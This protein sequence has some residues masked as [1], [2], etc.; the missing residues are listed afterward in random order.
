MHKWVLD[1]LHCDWTCYSIDFSKL[2]IHYFSQLT[3]ATVL[4]TFRWFFEDGNGQCSKGNSSA[5]NNWRVIKRCYCYVFSP[6]R[7]I[8]KKPLVD[9]FIR[10]IHGLSCV[11]GLVNGSWWF[12][13][14]DLAALLPRETLLWKLQM[15]RPASEFANSR[16]SAVK[17]QTLVLSRSV[18]FGIHCVV[19]K[20]NQKHTTKAVIWHWHSRC[21]WIWNNY[22][23]STIIAL[24]IIVLTLTNCFRSSSAHTISCMII[25]SFA[26]P[27]INDWFV[28]CLF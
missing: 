2:P 8:N 10:D 11:V 22:R 19:E 7:Q 28:A 9:S 20:E 21:T 17:A 5:S 14:Q 6:Q 16:L 15:L 13:P 4:H 24:R 1:Q 23:E 25:V 26:S 27:S 3:P 18:S 12:M